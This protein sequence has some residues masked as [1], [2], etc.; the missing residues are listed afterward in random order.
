MVDADLDAPMPWLAT[1]GNSVLPGY[2]VVT[3]GCFPDQGLYVLGLA[4][5]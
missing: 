4:R 1:A 3:S 2:W 5:V